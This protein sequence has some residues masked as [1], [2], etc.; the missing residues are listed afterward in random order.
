MKM[1]ATE[2]RALCRRIHRQYRKPLNLL[3]VES[4]ELA[5]L[6]YW[7]EMTEDRLFKHL[8]DTVRDEA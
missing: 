2:Y 8:D 6:V 3:Y 7:G 4:C 5:D 1:K